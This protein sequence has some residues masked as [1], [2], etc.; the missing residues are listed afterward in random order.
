MS[1]FD[2]MINSLNNT[3]EKKEFCDK[4]NSLSFIYKEAHKILS[5]V[6]NIYWCFNLNL[7]YEEPFS[8]Q[9]LL[10]T[11]ATFSSYISQIIS[12][13]NELNELYNSNHTIS[14]SCV[15]EYNR[16][17]KL[18]TTMVAD[19]STLIKNYKTMDRVSPSERNKYVIKNLE[20]G[21]A[22]LQDYVQTKHVVLL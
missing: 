8:R 7:N 4:V 2:K 18:C 11:F 12:S 19:L 17:N 6:N 20:L 5:P 21:L 14:S 3:A 22:R 9:D 13:H 16:A 15:A 1:I 10:I